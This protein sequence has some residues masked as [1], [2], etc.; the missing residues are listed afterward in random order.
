MSMIYISGA[1]AGDSYYFRKFADAE[2]QLR[3]KGWRVFNPAKVGD[4]G[5]DI[6]RLMGIDL[7]AVLASSAVFALPD[8]EN[9]KGAEI[10]L[11]AR[12]K[13]EILDQWEKAISRAERDFPPGTDEHKA[14][15]LYY[16]GGQ[17]LTDIAKAMHFER[18]AII[19]KKD[20]FVYRV[21]WYA[22][23]AGLTRRDT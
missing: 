22:A 15:L 14:A 4:P 5:M 7:A 2:A 23:E 19:R 13:L 11:R 3:A 10:V 1:I 18:Q 21:A 16:E 12:E 8:W 9:S 17:K 20:A 6:R